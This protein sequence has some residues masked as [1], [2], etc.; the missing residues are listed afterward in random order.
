M[1]QKTMSR[2]PKALRSETASRTLAVLQDYMD[3]TA[4]T[5]SLPPEHVYP[6]LLGLFGEVGSVMA[7][8][9]KCHRE[10]DSYK[11]TAYL[12]DLKEELG[13]ALW[14][15]STLCRRL[16]YEA[17]EIFPDFEV[18]GDRDNFP[19]GNPRD[20]K[21]SS[22][23]CSGKKRSLDELLQELGEAA[24]ALLRVREKSDATLGLLRTFAE[25]YLRTV[26]AKDVAFAGVV[27]LNIQKTRG[28]FLKPDPSTLRD[29]DASF[30][31]DERLPDKFEIEII[32]RP[33]GQSYMRWKG[34]FIGDPLTDN[35]PDED[36]YRFHDVF[37]LSYAAVLHWSPI[38]RKLTKQK[39]K[40][41]PKIDEAEDGGRA[42]V[43]E[44][45]VSAWI[46]SQAKRLDFFEGHKDV[47]FDLLKA[48]K[49]FVS[50]YEVE[51]C[52]LYLWRSAIL[53]GYEV[54][55]EV[56]KNKGGVVVGNRR[57]RT[58]AY[59]PLKPKS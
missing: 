13:D 4:P 59:K 17:A 28:R 31:E 57:K 25:S 2:E 1:A 24:A 15:F 11:S 53:Q 23:D 42:T 27:D 8:A 34:V 58:I 14:Y 39:R 12:D 26:Q 36:G 3:R 19:A 21:D 16:G 46:F 38:F 18:D 22:G 50:G 47:P 30:P 20:E 5:D 44:E 45:G 56:R 55:R 32:Q 33:S 29:F 35:I 54:F 51:A 6:V 9:K 40:S 48:V 37:H 43:V 7:V 41:D 49:K 10:S 52:P